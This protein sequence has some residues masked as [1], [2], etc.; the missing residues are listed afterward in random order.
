MSVKVL[1][2]LLKWEI[3]LGRVFLF[4]GSSFSSLY[5]YHVI[6]FW[7]VDFLLKNQ[8]IAWWEFLCMLFVVFLFA[9]NI[10]SL[11]SIFVNLLSLCLW[12]S[13]S[14]LCL[15]LYTSFVSFPRLEKLSAI[16]PDIFLVIFSLSS[17]SMT[18]IM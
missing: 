14:L 6:P 17:P 2:S 13:L 3:L 9:F 10:L 8:L 1:I 12:S 18:P 11:S 4:V 16:S 5:K 15:G 7:F